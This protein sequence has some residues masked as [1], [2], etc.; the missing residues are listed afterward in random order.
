MPDPTLAEIVSAI[1]EQRPGLLPER[2]ETND[3][4]IS[5]TLPREQFVSWRIDERSIRLSHDAEPLAELAVQASLFDSW[6]RLYD[7]DLDG[8]INHVYFTATMG[9]SWVSSPM[10]GESNPTLFPPTTRGC[11]LAICHAVGV[12]IVGG[13]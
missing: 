13:V 12:E 4:S 1:R 6:A 8:S 9:G 5:P 10:D 3:F 11:I 2:M 7:G